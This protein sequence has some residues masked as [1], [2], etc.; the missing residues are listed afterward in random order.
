[1]AWSSNPARINAAWARCSASRARRAAIPPGLAARPCTSSARRSWCSRRAARSI[2]TRRVAASADIWSSAASRSWTR[3]R[4][5]GCSQR[6]AASRRSARP[7]RSS[8]SRSV[9]SN[10]MAAITG[11]R[12]NASGAAGRRGA[13]VKLKLAEAAT[14][15]HTARR[16]ARPDSARAARRVSSTAHTPAAPSRARNS[17]YGHAPRKP[18]C[19]G[20]TRSGPGH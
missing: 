8:S 1:M 6:S 16:G 17:R 14:R 13:C 19:R 20:R 12:P 15:P 4:S 9:N 2:R 7:A 11:M 5:A 3:T 10:K 18:C